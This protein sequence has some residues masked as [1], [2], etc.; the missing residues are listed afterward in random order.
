MRLLHTKKLVL[1]EFAADE[2]PTYAI[3]SHTWSYGEVSFQDISTRNSTKRMA[4]QKLR[5]A[6][7]EQV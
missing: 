6:A 5:K 1:K 2:I 3:L 7:F 4:S